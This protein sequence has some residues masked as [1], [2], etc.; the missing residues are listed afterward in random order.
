MR[1]LL[2]V[3]I[4]VAAAAALPGASAAQ[5]NREAEQRLLT[6]SGEGI[7]TASPDM[8]TI[9]LGVVTEEERARAA[10]SA[11]TASMTGIIDALKAEGLESRDLQTSGFSVE[12]IYSQP[13]PNYDHSKPFY[14]Q[15]L[16]YRVRNN[17]TVRIRE[18]ERVGAILDAVITLGANSVSGPNFTVENPQPLEDE[19]RRIAMSD[20]LR[21]GALYAE[22]GGVALGPVSRIEESF[23]RPPQPMQEAA[24]MRMAVSDSAV[25]IE[26][27]ELTFQAQV[28]VSW[29]LAE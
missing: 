15:I 22:A 7:V 11:N 20:A 6:L 29:Q 25:P 13:P 10:L 26:G 5:N 1:R 12:A 17:L 24:M 9:T 19:A 4:V 3:L 14:P 28:S 8:A 21:K 16:G 27:G 2:S 18:L 23:M